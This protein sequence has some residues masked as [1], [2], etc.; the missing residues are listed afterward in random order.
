LESV[1]KLFGNA[2]RILHKQR[3]IHE[4]SLHH[5]A[6]ENILTPCRGSIKSELHFL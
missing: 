6:D 4:A 5:Q 3:D 2:A 1:R